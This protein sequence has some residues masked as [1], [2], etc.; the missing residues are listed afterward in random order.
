[1][2]FVLVSISLRNI[3]MHFCF[4]AS[5]SQAM[6][7]LYQCVCEQVARIC[8]LAQNSQSEIFS[9]KASRWS[10]MKWERKEAFKCMFGM[11]STSALPASV[12]DG[13]FVRSEASCSPTDNTILSSSCRRRKLS[14]ANSS[15]WNSWH[16]NE[17]AVQNRS[18]MAIR[19]FTID[20]PR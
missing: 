12:L 18:P 10:V 17:I 7:P 14:K 1:M 13:T 20:W 6:I 11:S 5:E 16:L 8:A 4:S 2:F 3:R 9:N 19:T 15:P